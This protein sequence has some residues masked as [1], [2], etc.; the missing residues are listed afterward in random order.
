MA[1]EWNGG[2]RDDSP[3]FSTWNQS[4]GVGGGK[5]QLEVG[6]NAQPMDA[7]YDG[8]LSLCQY[9]LRLIIMEH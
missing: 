4:V 5:T 7:T 9:W 8:V 6:A 2:T 3:T 1:M